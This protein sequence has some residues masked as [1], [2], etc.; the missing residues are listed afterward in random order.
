MR[1]IYKSDGGFAFLPGRSQ[2]FTLDSRTLPE[3]EAGQLQTLV[4]R[5]RVLEQPSSVEQPPILAPDARRY[6]ITVQVGRRRRT[7]CAADPI[8]D[9]ELRALVEFLEHVRREHA[10]PPE[11]TLDVGPP[12]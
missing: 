9:P 8:G 7:V 4:E 6:T 12:E 1:V 11:D 2:P 5:A 10:A 3:A